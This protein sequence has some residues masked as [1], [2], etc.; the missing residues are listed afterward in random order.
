MTTTI[1]L[2][3]QR[4]YFLT[5]TGERVIISP[6][7]LGNIRAWAIISNTLVFP[8]L[9]SPTTTTLQQNKYHIFI[10]FDTNLNL[11]DLECCWEFLVLKIIHN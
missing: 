4:A 2:L 7:P 5:L 3:I 1:S 9:W 10:F 11:I 6:D 8:A